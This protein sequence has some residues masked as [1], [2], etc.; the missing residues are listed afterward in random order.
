[1]DVVDRRAL[2]PYGA[3]VKPPRPTLVRGEIPV[4]AAVPIEQ[5]PADGAAMR[6]TDAAPCLLDLV[7]GH[8]PDDELFAALVDDKVGALGAL[9]GRH[10]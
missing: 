5:Q 7:R 9:R 1:M 2:K 3:R 4:E 10:E 6:L 8:E